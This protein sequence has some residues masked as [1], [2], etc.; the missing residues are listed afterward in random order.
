MKTVLKEVFISMGELERYYDG[1]VPV[2]LWR[3]LNIK[4]NVSLFDL[5]EKPFKMPNGRIRKPDIEI[6]NGWVKVKH[7]PRGISTFDK[8]GVPKGKDWVHYKLPAGTLLPKGLA[9]VK[10][11]FND[12]FQATHYTIA[13]A[14]D[15]PLSTFKSLLNQLA[16][17][18]NREAK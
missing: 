2:N 15:M 6:D 11:S 17:I 9:I 4:K 18:A 1:I 7:W 8:P 5:I 16:L 10:D 14:Y 13:P 12:T 3:G